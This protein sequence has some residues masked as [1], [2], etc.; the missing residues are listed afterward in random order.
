MP[1]VGNHSI[2]LNGSFQQRDTASIVF[3]NRFANARGFQDYNLSRMWKLGAN[4]HFPIVY[5]DLGTA[6]ILYVQRVRG[7]LFYD[8]ARAYS[9]DKLRSR[10]FKSVGGEMYFDTKWW[11]Q[12]PVTFGFRISH[13]LTQGLLAGDNKGSTYFEFIL[14]VNL[15]PN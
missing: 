7:N 2:V 8:F 5:P 15:I 4:Y 14:P 10:D 9:N 11:N 1:S 6:N 12:L 13:L 3:S